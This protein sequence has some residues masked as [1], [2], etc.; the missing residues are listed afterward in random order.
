LFSGSGCASSGTTRDSHQQQWGP[1]AVVDEP[2]S[3][4]GS[5]GLGPGTLTIGEECVTLYVKDVDR[6]ITLVWRRADV[7]WDQNSR[8]ITYVRSG[9]E[10][11]RLANGATILVGGVEPTNRFAAWLVRPAASC[12]E[13]LFAVHDL[14][15]Q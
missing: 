10:R 8:E 5:A 13:A 1:L 9:D 6:H 14:T 12:P 2:A 7:M 15:I 3:G 11:V 4:G